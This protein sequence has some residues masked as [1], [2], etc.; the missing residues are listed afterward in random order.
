MREPL[1][2]AIANSRDRLGAAAL[3]TRHPGTTVIRS[4]DGSRPFTP[5]EIGVGRF[6]GEIASYAA[7]AGVAVPPNAAPDTTTSATSR[8]TASNRCM[9]RGYGH[10]LPS[11]RD[12]PSPARAIAPRTRE[13]EGRWSA[14]GAEAVGGG[15]AGGVGRAGDEEERGVDHG[16]EV[17]AAVVGE[18]RLGRHPKRGDGARADEARAQVVAVVETEA[19]GDRGRDHHLPLLLELERPREKAR[20]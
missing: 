7:A 11:G 5:P 19:R 14:A 3:A 8:R 4:L 10:P 16:P 15:P 9:G 12:R 17:A 6:P 18:P 2:R 1:A 13:R 20:R